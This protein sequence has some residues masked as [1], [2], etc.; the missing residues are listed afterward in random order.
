MTAEALLFD[1]DGTLVDSVDLHAR[2][3][4]EAFEH[5]G[6]RISLAKI[7][8]QIGKGADELL[9]TL[10]PPEEFEKRCEEIDRW[11]SDLYKRKYLGQVRAFRRVRELFQE[12]LR[13]KL[14]I[15]APA[16]LAHMERMVCVI[17]DVE[18]RPGQALHGGPQQ[19]EMRQLVARA[20]QKKHGNRDFAQMR[21]P[22]DAALAGRMERKAD[23]R[24]P[25]HVWERRERLGLRG[26]PA[27]HRLA[28]GEERKSFLRRGSHHLADAFVQDRRRID[29]PPPFFHVRKLVPQRRDVE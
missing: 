28:S 7:R 5:F 11:R 20:L 3:W 16:L 15:A 13:R 8:A 25:E 9:K 27:A 17:D 4:E 2:A 12:V 29:A 1:I 21:G 19:I 23:E 22:L 14:R 26:H 6:R 10:L 24:E 18:R